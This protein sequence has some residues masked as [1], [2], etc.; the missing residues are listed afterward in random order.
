MFNMKTLLYCFA[1]LFVI[2]ACREEEPFL[3]YEGQWEGSYSNDT[4][5]LGSMNFGINE[6]GIIKGSIKP[7]T[8]LGFSYE[9]RG[10]ITPDGSFQAAST[11]RS[12][13]L[14][15][16]GKLADDKASGT[17]LEEP[18]TGNGSWEARKK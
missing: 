1:L 8:S 14:S 18:G 6:R 3:A 5:S 16:I 4:A 9:L 2:S 7:D 11:L 15:Y 10:S 13:S 17:W 12:D